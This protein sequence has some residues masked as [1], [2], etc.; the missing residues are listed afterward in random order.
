MKVYTKNKAGGYRYPEDMKRILDYLS[1][2]GT[3]HVSGSTVEEM[4]GDFS[5]DRYCAGWM[6]VDDDLLEEFADWLDEIDL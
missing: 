3:L 2:H 6:S 4:Y 1:E 5:E